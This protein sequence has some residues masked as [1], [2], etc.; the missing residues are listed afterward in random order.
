[1]VATTGSKNNGVF[2]VTTSGPLDPDIRGDTSYRT[3][4][5]SSIDQR[6]FSHTT[7]KRTDFMKEEI[8]GRRTARCDPHPKT[9]DSSHGQDAY[10]LTRDRSDGL[11]ELL[12]SNPLKQSLE[13]RKNSIKTTFNP[14][15]ELRKSKEKLSR[16]NN[17]STGES[18]T[19]NIY[20]EMMRKTT[21]RGQNAINI[22]NL[23][24]IDQDRMN[25]RR[26]TDQL[27]AKPS[28]QRS[29]VK[30]FSSNEGILKT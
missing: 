4:G 24:F 19:A 5:T 21:T 26:T 27:R 20:L 3:L 29:H 2:N 28:K 8:R 9:T 11:R 30:N 23:A 10:S 22:E 18:A 16:D 14:R 17:G 25:S 15:D 13:F 1:M 12:T 7:N 6:K